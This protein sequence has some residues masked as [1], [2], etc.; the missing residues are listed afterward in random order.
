MSEVARRAIAERAYT[1]K[2]GPVGPSPLRNELPFE[3]YQDG[4]EH[5]RIIHDLRDGQ[6]AT[7]LNRFV[8]ICRKGR[9]LNGAQLA[10][11]ANIEE[12]LNDNICNNIVQV[13][14]IPEKTFNSIRYL[15]QRG[16]KRMQKRPNPRIRGG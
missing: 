14:D 15:K 4:H 8:E 6:T 5:T 11:I 9:T 7:E 1:R 2:R 16:G 10:R 3:G 13:K 12:R